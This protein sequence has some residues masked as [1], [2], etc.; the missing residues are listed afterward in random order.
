LS[1]NII[2]I[3]RSPTTATPSSL[4][5][6]ELAFSNVTGGSGVLFIGSTDGGSVVPIGGQ[7][8]PGT[9]TANQALVVNST[10]G[11]NRIIAAN[12]DVLSFLTV[13]GSVGSAGWILYSGGAGANAYWASA[14]SLGINTNAQYI[15][16]NTQTFQNTVTFS[17]TINI[18]ANAVINSTAYYWVGNTTTSPTVSIANS[19]VIQ[20]GNSSVTAAPQVIVANT[21]GTT[22]INTNAIS[23]TTFVTGSGGGSATGG[24][25]VNSSIALVGNSTANAYVNSTVIG[26]VN[27]TANVTLTPASIFVGTASV[28][29]TINSTSIYW[30]GTAIIN[31]T[32][33]ALASNNSIN[34]NGQPASYYTNATNITTGTLPYAQLGAAVVNTSG[35]FTLAGNTTLAGTNTVIS[36]N[37]TVT[38][39]TITGTTTDVNFRNGT[40][41]GNLTISGT[42]T[43][44]NT[45]TLIV[46]DNII[47]LG[48]N[49]TTTDTI[50][51]G[52][53]SPAGNSTSIWYSGMARVAAKS[54]NNN[55][56][57]WLFASNTN[58]N[59][60]S[61]IDTSSN[62]STA[63]L[64]AYLAPYGTGGAFI[65]NS[66]VVNITANSTVSATLTANTL[67][68][69]TALGAASGGT[70]VLGSTYAAGDLLYAATG[71]PAALSRLSVP[72]SAANGQVLQII[73]NLPAYGVIDAGTF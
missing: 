57:F 24:I 67:T 7:R 17:T 10:S 33:G 63:T 42:V 16:S 34:L 54:A 50:D 66:S 56:W 12:V 60:A 3:K 32:G 49:N 8:V 64:Q 21:L 43:S 20:S 70:G 23:T 5:P 38:G 62:T 4:N 44:I 39:A 31:S 68:L 59:T 48:D 28:N 45:Q 9:L 36:S 53:Y 19:G 2:Q 61:T 71:A 6:G 41:S 27:S 65:A 30:N 14:G 26:I 1:N 15:W 51:T 46:N 29:T 18:A 72:G 47:E 11:I 55:A 52:W 22:T 25:S 13:N 69:T 58:P 37:L 35:S 73:N 40:F